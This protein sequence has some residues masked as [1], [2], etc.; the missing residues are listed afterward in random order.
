MVICI[1][2][3]I[4]IT[5]KTQLNTLIIFCPLLFRYFTYPELNNES[6]HNAADHCDEVER[7][8]GIFEEVLLAGTVE[9]ID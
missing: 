3:Y 6:V 5:A 8:P 9:K 7:I 1:Y 2:I 4:Y